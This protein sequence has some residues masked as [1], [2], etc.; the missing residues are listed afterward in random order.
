[1][2]IIGN[3]RKHSW[4]AVAIVGIAIIAFIIGDLTKNRGGIPDMGKI[5]G[6]TVTPQHFNSLTD[7]MEAQMKQ[8][9]GVAQLPSDVEYRIREQ[10]WQELIQQTLFNEEYERL[11]LSIS[12]AELNDMYTGTFIHPTLRQQFTDP[13]TGQ[14]NTQIIQYYVDNFDQLDTLQKASWVE[15]EEY[16]QNDRLQQ[17]YSALWSQALYMPKAIAE[18]MVEI[19]SKSADARVAALSLQSINDSESEPTDADYQK[20]YNEHKAELRIREEYRHLEYIVFPIVPTNEDMAQIQSDVMKLWAEFQEMDTASNSDMAFF[21]NSESDRSYDSTFVASTSFAAPFDSLVAHTAVG[22]YIE[23]QIVGNQWMMGKVMA[24]QQRPDSLR[25]RCIWIL[26]GQASQ[27]VSR[28][29]EQAKSLADS[30]SMLLKSGKVSFENA[31][32]EYSENKEGDGDMGWALDGGYGFLNE[33]IVNTPVGGIFTLQHPQKVGYMVVEVTGKTT[34]KQKYRVATI[35]RNIVPSNATEKSVYNTANFFAG[36]NRTREA[37]ISAAQ[38]QNLAVR[39]QDIRLMDNTLGGI[40]NA[41]SIVQWAYGDDVIAGEVADQVFPCDNV[42]VVCA[43]SDVFPKGYLTLEQARPYI[44]Q[45]VRLEKKGE[46]A[47]ARAEEAVKAGKDVNSI[48]AKLGTVVDSMSHISFNDFYFG[49]Y[50]MEPKVQAAVA[51][52]AASGKT[53]FVGP[54]RGASGVYMVQIDNIVNNENG[55]DVSTIQRQQVQLA[56]QKLSMVLSLLVEKSKI[57]D[58]RNKFF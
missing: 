1:M 39:N 57:T 38:E 32:Q 22:K 20:Y 29:D 9:Q 5:N 37:M 23:P 12:P 26:N 18:K 31:V 27:S 45:M 50:G 16:V 4:L 58:Q 21:V 49:R 14:Y 8:Q 55:N 47:M 54:V 10:V 42:Y 19:N 3:I 11:G 17:K 43:L 15:L 13:Q 24:A 28:T 41:R 44:E 35:T 48:A 51:A 34:P 46:V 6:V 30:V 33:Q 53:G 56:Q 52:Q 36:Q 40:Q 7:R 2:G 25:A